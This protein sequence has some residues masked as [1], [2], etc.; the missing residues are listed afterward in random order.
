MPKDICFTVDFYFPGFEIESS[1]QLEMIQMFLGDDLPSLGFEGRKSGEDFIAYQH[2]AS[3]EMSE[4]RDVVRAAIQ[5]K[6]RERNPM[7]HQE[8]RVSFVCDI[9][10]GVLKQCGHHN[11]DAIHYAWTSW[12]EGLEADGIITEHQRMHVFDAPNLTKNELLDAYE[13]IHQNG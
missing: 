8:A 5:K 13:R 4:K 12:V 9:L 11:G 6:L 3:K 10:P 2:R 7:T 1:G